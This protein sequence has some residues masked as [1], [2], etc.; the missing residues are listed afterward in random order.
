MHVGTGIIYEEEGVGW[1]EATP[2]LPAMLGVCL[3]G[4]GGFAAG[5][6]AQILRR[7]SDGWAVEDTG[8]TLFETFHGCF[9]DPDGGVW[10]V[11]GRVL[12]YPLTCGML[13]H[14]GTPVPVGE[15]GE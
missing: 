6:A 4:E 9:V 12:D 5:E 8:L 14:F 3:H 11:G 10:A 1:A 13:A 15:Y 7:G 2:G